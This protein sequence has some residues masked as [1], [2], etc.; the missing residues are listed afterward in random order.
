MD[1]ISI[2][3]AAFVSHPR[4]P[5]EH[6]ASYQRRGDNSEFRLTCLECNFMTQGS[7]RD[8]V[9]KEWNNHLPT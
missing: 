5:G 3:A 2:A 8:F 9:A 6:Q 1:N 7:T 4:V